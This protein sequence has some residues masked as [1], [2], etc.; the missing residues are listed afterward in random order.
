MAEVQLTEATG[1]KPIGWSQIDSQNWHWKWRR[2]TSWSPAGWILLAEVQLT[3]KDKKSY[4]I[5]SIFVWRTLA[6]VQMAEIL[7]AE[8]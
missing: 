3:V 1:G 6:E 8:V 7:S 2:Q 4:S 5:K